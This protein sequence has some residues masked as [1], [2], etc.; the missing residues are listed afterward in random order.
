MDDATNHSGLVGEN[1]L[2]EGVYCPT[3][4]YHLCGVV[5]NRCPECGHD[6]TRIRSGETEIPWAKPDRRSR[7]IA[8]WHTVGLMLYPPRRFANEINN[9]VDVARA[10]S[11]WWISILLAWVAFG[12]ALWLF[13]DLWMCLDMPSAEEL[14]WPETDDP[15]FDDVDMPLWQQWAP[16]WRFE[17]ANSLPEGWPVIVFWVMLLPVL[18]GTSSI[19]GYWFTPPPRPAS[20]PDRGYG[21]SRYL[22]TPLVV[23]G[24]LF[25]LGSAA[26]PAVLDWLIRAP[27][28]TGDQVWLPLV[29]RVWWYYWVG[30]F[31]LMLVLT[32][33]SAQRFG[34]LLWPMRWLRWAALVPILPLAWLTW[35]GLILVGGP[36]AILWIG[37]LLYGVLFL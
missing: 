19:V 34:R 18:A 26:L 29:E 6:L 37:V 31:G 32:I 8:Y 28:D 20:Q 30:V 23:G 7:F 3:C 25:F 33:A 14:V 36:V 16:W 1:A 12:M 24:C 13:R 10:R 15:W 9:P 17:V 5:S 27:Y 2:P 21:L 11:F 4:R 22:A 35:V